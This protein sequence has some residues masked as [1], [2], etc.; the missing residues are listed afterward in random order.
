MRLVKAIFFTGL[1]VLVAVVGQIVDEY[2]RP[3][4]KIQM[5]RKE[6]QATNARK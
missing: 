3:Y 2:F 6:A 4:K 1:C 5:R